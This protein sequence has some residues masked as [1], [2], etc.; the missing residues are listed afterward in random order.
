MEGLHSSSILLIATIEELMFDWQGLAAFITGENEGIG[1]MHLNILHSATEVSAADYYFWC[2]VP[3]S[4]W[5][6]FC[7]NVVWGNNLRFKG[8]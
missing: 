4:S 3:L 2:C 7:Y 8:Q 6:Y 5:I 1:N